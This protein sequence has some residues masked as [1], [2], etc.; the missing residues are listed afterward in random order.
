MPVSEPTEKLE[1][2]S[3]DQIDDNYPKL[4]LSMDKIWGNGRN[5]V[6]R[7]YLPDFLLERLK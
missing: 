7:I 5:G 1:F 6:R 2:G 3:L 4:V